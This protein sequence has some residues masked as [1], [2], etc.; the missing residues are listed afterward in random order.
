[1]SENNVLFV[2]NQESNYSS[3][4]TAVTSQNILLLKM[5]SDNVILCNLKSNRGKA[6]SA[7]LLRLSFIQYK[8]IKK[9]IIK[10]NITHIFFNYSV[11]G[12]LIKKI[13]KFRKNINIISY[14]HNCEALYMHDQFKRQGLPFYFLYVLTILN[15]SAACKYSD[16][17]IFITEED[18]NEINRRYKFPLK[19]SNILPVLL[20]DKY[21]SRVGD[22]NFY[23]LF[24]GSAFFAN[25]EAAEYL[26]KEIL[27]NIPYSI[28]IAGT[29][30]DKALAKY[31]NIENLKIIG[32]TE[33]LN[34]LF[35]GASVFIAPIFSGSG[36]KVKIAEALMH[37]K[38]II[39]SEKAII[40]Y[41]KISSI[42]VC[43]ST[44]E[45]I[46]AINNIDVNKIFYQE[47]RDLFLKKYS[48][49]NLQYYYKSIDE[50]FN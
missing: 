38:K 3:G 16:K 41:E 49:D 19:K 18:K 47:S 36:M 15:E 30:M 40:G 28:V 34:K 43:K 25:I 39:C 37:G 46:T 6:L 20:N 7:L 8:K 17:C 5:F 44:N 1:M 33:E 13:K 14:F 31:N 42:I 32:F 9:I 4:G 10:N 29:N 21:A 24:F 22:D 45:Y 23:L 11:Y 50:I 48:I 35:A 2:Y 12:I 26:I 27:P